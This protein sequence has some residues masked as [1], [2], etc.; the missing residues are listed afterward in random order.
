MSTKTSGSF[1][2][3]LSAGLAQAV[4]AGSL[5]LLGLITAGFLR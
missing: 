4:A 3:P 1:S 5:L 2:S